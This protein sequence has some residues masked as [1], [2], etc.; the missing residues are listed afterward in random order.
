MKKISSELPHETW[1][2]II[3]MPWPGGKSKLIRLFLIIIG[4][5]TPAFRPGSE[6]ANLRIQQ[7]LLQ[8]EQWEI[9]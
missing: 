8:I 6:Q 5:N 7:V 2:R 3:G 1:E 9:L 4:P